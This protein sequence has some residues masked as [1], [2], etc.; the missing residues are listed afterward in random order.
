LR[1]MFSQQL[2]SCGHRRHQSEFEEIIYP[3]KSLVKYE[4]PRLVIHDE[5]FSCPTTSPH[6]LDIL[7]PPI[8]FFNKT[9]HKY[10]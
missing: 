8:E 2:M 5:I 4:T 7:F 3:K 6:I 9:N 1:E 10:V